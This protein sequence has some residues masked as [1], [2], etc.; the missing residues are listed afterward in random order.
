MVQCEFCQKEFSLKGLGGHKYSC[1]L[2]P[3]KVIRVSPFKGKAHSDEA[4]LKCSKAAIKQH[5][6]GL[7]FYPSWNGKKH[8]EESKLKISNSMKGNQNGQH[9]GDRQS[10]YK[11]IRMDSSWEVK[12]A[13]YFD[14]NDI[15]WSYNECGYILSDG[16]YYYP[17]FFI[18]NNDGK[19]I[20]LV[21]VKGYFRE[22]NRKKFEMFKNEYPNIIVE[23]WNKEVLKLKSII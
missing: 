9:R 4:K 5:Q 1:K 11:D 20:K 15:K 17:D 14:D 6:D 21:E 10:Y 3:N 22:A 18:Y 7:G 8:K 12:T 2:N 16:R 23:L 19:F 13:K